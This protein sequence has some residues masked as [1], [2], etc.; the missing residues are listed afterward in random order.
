MINGSYT[1]H[2]AA[3]D[4]E[5]AW[6]ETSEISRPDVINS[7]PILVNPIVLP[8][9]GYITTEFNYT[10]TYYDLDNHSPNSITVNISGPS[11][12]G[13]WIMIEVDI[14]DTNFIDGKEYYYIYTGFII[15]SYSFHCAAKDSQSAWR[16]TP[17]IMQPDV[18]NTQPS[19][20]NHN[21]LPTVG[22]PGIT[23]FN[24]TVT[25]SDLDN[26]AP[27]CINVTISGP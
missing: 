5:G 25:Y 8:A 4:S 21:L 10:V 13:N 14:L 26:Q 15:G 7:E 12:S 2:F 9:T 27:G 23:V 22:N 19:L 18:L 6:N 1:H 20:S 24:Y 16:E 11:H 3:S 17:E